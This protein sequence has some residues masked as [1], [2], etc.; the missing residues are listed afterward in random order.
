MNLSYGLESKIAEL[1]HQVTQCYC[2]SSQVLRAVYCSCHHLLLSVEANTA[3]SFSKYQE[4]GYQQIPILTELSKLL[5]SG[6]FKG[7]IFKVHRRC[8]LTVIL[9]FTVRGLRNQ[10]RPQKPFSAIWVSI[11]DIIHRSL[12]EETEP[13][14]VC[15]WQQ[16]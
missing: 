8:C 1:K 6:I 3:S 2:A 9:K 14:P 13:A 10:N 5:V 15:H 11:G 12:C 7:E 4:R 16:P